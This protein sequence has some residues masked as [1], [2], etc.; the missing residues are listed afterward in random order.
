[1]KRVISTNQMIVDLTSPFLEKCVYKDPRQRE[2]WGSHSIYLSIL[3]WFQNS[4]WFTLKRVLGELFF[5]KRKN[6]TYLG[7]NIP[8][9]E[10]LP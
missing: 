4:A 6:K 3:G 10:A 5:P 2:A 9:R 8:D 7:P 1:M